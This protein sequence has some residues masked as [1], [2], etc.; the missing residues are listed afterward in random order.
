M[1]N[2]PLPPK[3]N[4]GQVVKKKDIASLVAYGQ[5]RLAFPDYY[6]RVELP[7]VAGPLISPSDNSYLVYTSAYD[8]A[9]VSLEFYLSSGS[10]SYDM[11]LSSSN[12]MD[13]QFN[14]TINR[15]IRYL[16]D[17]IVKYGDSLYCNVIRMPDVLP[18]PPPIVVY[19]TVRA[20]KYDESLF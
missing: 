18:P 11:M 7:R 1:A 4:I 19:L 10:D 14:F 15:G 20:I 9:F 6:N 8:V 2:I 16:I 3:V 12:L 5:H 17:S 13:R